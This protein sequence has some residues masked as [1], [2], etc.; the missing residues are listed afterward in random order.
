MTRQPSRNDARRPGDSMR[1]H[2]ASLTR[3]LRHGGMDS[4][5]D[6]DSSDDSL[7]FSG[8]GGDGRGFV[9]DDRGMH[10]SGRSIQGGP[11]AGRGPGSHHANNPMGD[12]HLHPQGGQTGGRGM[13]HQEMRP[14]VGDMGQDPHQRPAGGITDTGLPYLRQEIWDLRARLRELINARMDTRRVEDR[15]NALSRELQCPFSRTRETPRGRITPL[16]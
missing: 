6:G 14:R 3:Q 15:I 5:F 16:A 12:M 9:F 13:P 4:D 11:P 7:T 2:N 8:R 10:P 1:L